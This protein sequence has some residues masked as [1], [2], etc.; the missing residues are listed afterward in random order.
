[1]KKARHDKNLPHLRK[2]LDPELMAPAFEELFRRDYPEAGLRVQHCR[3]G[4]V[5]HKPG[6]DCGIVYNLQCR[7]REQRVYEN[8][9]YGKMFANGK[10]Q[11]SSG[12]KHP[13]VWPGCGFWKPASLWPETEMVLYAFPYDNY[14]PHLGRLLEPGFVRQQVE[15]NLS[16][17]GAPQG[18]RCVEVTCEKIK[19]MPNKRCVLRYEAIIEQPQGVRQKVLF[20]SK[21]YDNVKS[22]YVY[23][24]LRELCAHPACNNGALNIPRPIAHL[25]QAHTLWQR[26]WEGE[27]FRALIKREGWENLSAFVP[28][29]AA[30]LATLH[31]IALQYAQLQAGPTCE[32]ILENARADVFDLIKFLPEREIAL[33]QIMQKLTSAVALFNGELPRATIHGTFKLA[34]F[35][36]REQQ[37]ALVDFDGIACG[38]PLYDVAEL[39]ASLAYLRVSEGLRAET[40]QLHLE[41]FLS[42]YERQVA[43][44]CTRARL[45]WYVA[46]FLL[47]KM[48]S[49]LKRLEK[50]AAGLAPAFDLL[51]EWLMIVGDRK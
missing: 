41:N 7:D 35:L 5:Y 12:K 22:R 38:D 29:I 14:L 4:R 33:L 49:S 50:K 43:W 18:S 27:E 2:A 9:F 24:V 15:E 17:F 39:V 31:G 40:A 30:M 21:T 6:K 16:G 11:A 37:L 28:K 47:G 45:A 20:Y 36:C 51:N 13:S 1:M 48:H 46:I 32:M 8:W 3:V 34:Q 25:E 44:P 23:E 42:A 10:V 19:Y 26:A